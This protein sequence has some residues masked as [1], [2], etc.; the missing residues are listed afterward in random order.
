MR[1]IRPGS[2]S[3]IPIGAQHASNTPRIITTRCSA[4]A[5]W[6]LGKLCWFGAPA[7]ELCRLFAIGTRPVLY[8]AN[9]AGPVPRS[10]PWPVVCCIVLVV[11][12]ILR[13]CTQVPA[14]STSL[15]LR[16]APG[17]ASIQSDSQPVQSWI[18]PR[19]FRYQT[20]SNPRYRQ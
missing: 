9:R 20:L 6:R 16:T 11:L 3:E 17:R 8:C 1:P 5:A 18:R 7:L 14:C 13:P 4:G 10:G 12:A 15:R 19:P 2:G